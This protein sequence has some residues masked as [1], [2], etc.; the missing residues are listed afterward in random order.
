MLQ[1]NAK[2]KSSNSPETVNLLKEAV[3]IKPGIGVMIAKA[4]LDMS[5]E[6]VLPHG[7]ILIVHTFI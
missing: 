3:G 6:K 2:L 1:L 4:L 5:M 7:L